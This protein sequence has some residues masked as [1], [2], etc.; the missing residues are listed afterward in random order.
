MIKTLVGI[1]LGL[2]V[3][4]I[5]LSIYLQPDDL[6]GCGT[7]PGINAPC[8]SVDAIVAISG[9]D[10]NARADQAISLYENGWAPSL[11]FSGAAEDKSGPSNAEAMKLRAVAAGVPASHIYIDEDSATTK[12]NA[13]N[14]DTIFQ[15]HNIKTI[16]LVTSGYHQRRASLEFEHVSHQVKVY[17][18]PV[19]TDDE[20][21]FWWWVT[22][23]GWWLALTEVAKIIMFYVGLI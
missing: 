20:W 1:V 3:V 17:N 6:H 21:S 10:T 5:G 22:P 8:A 16:I 11:I 2:A 18:D 14:S 19:L 15:S 4:I 7:T 12:E 13:T 9:G 23:I